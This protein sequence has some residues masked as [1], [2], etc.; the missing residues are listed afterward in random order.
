MSALDTHGRACPKERPKERPK[1]ATC[2]TRSRWAN[3]KKHTTIPLLPLLFVAHKNM[4]Q[5]R[6][7]RDNFLGNN[8]N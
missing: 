8:T 6:H 2:C 4:G 1:E 3:K 5:G 7:Y